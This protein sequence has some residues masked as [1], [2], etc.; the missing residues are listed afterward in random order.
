[1]K[2]KCESKYSKGSR[3][4]R[5]VE[6]HYEEL[7]KYLSSLPQ[8]TITERVKLRKQKTRI[9]I[10]TLASNNLLARLPV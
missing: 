3:S 9:G 2:L 1:M 5:E 8:G 4:V 7:S 6:D 10:K